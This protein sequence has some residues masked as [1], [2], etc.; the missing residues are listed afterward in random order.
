MEDIPLVVLFDG[1]CVMCNGATAWLARR[2]RLGR[3]IFATNQG[4]A[5]RVAGEPP[6]GDSDTIVVW[7]GSR[8]LVRSA[9]V[10]CLLRTLGGGWAALA[11]VA[12]LCPEALRDFLYGQ[13]A[14]RR[15]RFGGASACKRLSPLA[16]AE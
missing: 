8:R 6:G 9:A 5:A 10:L 15:H 13:I 3:M 14:R 2:D 12:R 7:Q 4:E 11:W 16:L 1:D